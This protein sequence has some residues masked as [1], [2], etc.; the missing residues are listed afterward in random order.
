MASPALAQPD[1]CGVPAGLGIGIASLLSFFLVDNV[2]GGTIADGRTAATTT[3][4]V[5]GLALILLLERGPG[6][7]PAAGGATGEVSPY[8]APAREKDLSGLPPAYVSTMEFDPLRDEGE[9][10]ADK[11][12]AAGVEVEYQRFNG[13]FHGFMLL[14]KLI[15]EG[16]QLIAAQCEF[17]KQKFAR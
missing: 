11:L 6:R 4:I 2:F 16:Q 3:L 15:P 7:G 9:A 12:K 8:A 1:P 10:Y 5:I 13:V 14:A 17:I